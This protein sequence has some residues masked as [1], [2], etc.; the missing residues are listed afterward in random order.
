V[1]ALGWSEVDPPHGRARAKDKGESREGTG[2]EPEEDEDSGALP[3]VAKDEAVAAE[4]LFPKAGKTSPP[5]RMTEA[6][7][8]GAMQGAGK[9]LDDEELKGA[10]KDCGLGTPATRAN[11]IETLLKRSY[12][13]RKRSILQPTDKGLDLIASLQAETLKSPQL[14]GEWEA[15]MERIRRGEAGREAFMQGIRTFV[16]EMVA[17]IKAAAP[18]ASARPSGPSAGPCPRCGAD[19]V[20]RS[21]EGRHYVKCTAS[22]SD[23]ECRVAYDTDPEGKPLETCG[24]CRGP[25]RTNRNGSKV[26][27]LCGRWVTDQDAD[28]PDPGVCAN[29]GK[30]M[31]LVPSTAKGKYFR[32]CAPCGVLQAVE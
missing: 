8:L 7:L 20:L 23:P 32:R 28:L 29:C 31:R 1:K 26:C 10:M 17:Q 25:V 14:T 22:G 5:K 12:V 16:Q 24:L 4:E 3:A 9:D 6:D 15:R 2:E 27:V 18:R 13:E 21:W 11:I 30:P 19:L